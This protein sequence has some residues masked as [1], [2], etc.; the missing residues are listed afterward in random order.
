MHELLRSAG[1]HDPVSQRMTGVAVEASERVRSTWEYRI[2]TEYV[3]GV[4]AQ[5][6]AR[7]LTYVGASPDLIEAAFG[8]AGDELRHASLVA[9]LCAAAGGASA[10]PIDP[11]LLAFPNPDT[12]L[13]DL[14]VGTVQNFCIAETVATRLFRHIHASATV[15]AARAVLDVIVEDEPRHG[16]LGWAT[17]DWLLESA[18]RDDVRRLIT[19][20]LDG[21]IAMFDASYCAASGAVMED[22]RAW[23]IPDGDDVAA[24]WRTC[25]ATDL[26][27]RF[28]KRGLV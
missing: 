2:T 8:V 28:A 14:V 17:L 11:A 25:L 9:G 12:V 20:E 22:E 1:R 5:D 15:A 13:T 19:T 26:V 6:H 16:A 21:W 18:W 7:R 4:Y 10:T 23:G 3:S 24:A 27:P